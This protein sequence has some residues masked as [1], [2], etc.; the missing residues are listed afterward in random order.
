MISNMSDFNYGDILI[1]LAEVFLP[2]D[3]RVGQQKN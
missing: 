1:S 3:Q 2:A